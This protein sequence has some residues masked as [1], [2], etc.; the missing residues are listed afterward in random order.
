[1]TL[2]RLI[3]LPL[4]MLII[5]GLA[6]CSAGH[7]SECEGHGRGNGEYARDVRHDVEVR[8]GCDA[9]YGIDARHGLA[10]HGLNVRQG[11]RYARDGS[12]H[13]LLPERQEERCVSR[14][15]VDGG[16][17]AQDRAGPSVDG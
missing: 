4:A 12:G 10:R 1:M 14:L 15:S 3:T 7:A 2:R 8:C 9:G 16:L 6:F 17:R 11:S 5:A 13:A